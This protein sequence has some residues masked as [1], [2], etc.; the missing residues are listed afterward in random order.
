MT[1]YPINFNAAMV[2]ALLAGRKTQTRRVLTPQ[3]ATIPAGQ[4]ADSYCSEQKTLANPRGMSRDWCLW[5]ADNR[6]GRDFAG[7]PYV[8]GD[9]LWVQTDHLSRLT[10]IVTDVRVQRVQDISTD[11]I[12]A[13]GTPGAWDHT[14]KHT[15]LVACRTAFHDLWDAIHAK[16]PER[17]WNANPWVCALTFDVVKANIDGVTA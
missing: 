1:D 17:Q 8:P 12:Y 7:V 16:R 4:Y 6:Q 15:C 2:Q 3:P 14:G 10:L 11:D 13:E 9:R 5:T